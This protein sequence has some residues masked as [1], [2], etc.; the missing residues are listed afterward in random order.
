[1][2]YN[3][4]RL[5]ALMDQFD[6]SGLVAS[7][8]ENI[9]YLS[10]FS[11]WKQR[12]YRH[13]NTQVYV[14]FPRDKGHKP[15]L[16]VSEGDEA[17]ASQQDLW[18]KEIFKYGKGKKAKTP[19][20]KELTPEE[21]R[22]TAILNVDPKGPNHVDVLIQ[23]LREK[24]MENS[25][26]GIDHLGLGEGTFEKLNT[27]LTGTELLRA[28][29][30][31][32]YVRMVKSDN[33]IERLKCAAALNSRAA[34]AILE[35][36][37]QGVSEEELASLYRMEIARAGGEV[38]W[39]H[40]AASRGANFPP[41]K[42]RIL[43][44]GDILRMDLGCRFQGYHADTCRSGCV[45]NPGDKQRKIFDAIQAG[46]SRSVEMLSPGVFSSE[47]FESML[48]GVKSAGLPDFSRNFVG[49]MIGLEA[50]GFPF[51]LG[52]PKDLNDPFLPATTDVP[53]EAGMVVN[54]EA[55]HHELG[56]G[57]V[58]VEYTLVVTEHGYEHIIPSEQILYSL[59]LL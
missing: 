2:L 25:R 39:L 16:I 59:P 12:N 1:M 3:E 26:I 5:L 30:F 43:I 50:R 40:M 6:L 42:D 32:L 48:Q 28:S 11:S 34:R 22:F 31:F 20:G 21:R 10:G 15:A 52:Q 35:K 14:V 4:K 7:T 13:G 37:D 55:S 19:D 41:L 18:I 33:E 45:G 44:K 46:V 27:L 38:D 49:H 58:S 29:N 8:P 24:G 51:A 53:M 17:Y 54:L 23:V 9:F 36:A 56:W 57:S 47:L